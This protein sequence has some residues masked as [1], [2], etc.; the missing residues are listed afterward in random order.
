MHKASYEIWGC[1]GWR[2]GGFGGLLLMRAGWVPAKAGNGIQ[3]PLVH[4]HAMGSGLLQPPGM[5]GPL[6]TPSPEKGAS[7]I[8][9]PG[10]LQGGHH[11]PLPPC[12]GTD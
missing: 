1:S 10:F 9:Y 7:S 3:V 8:P 4:R 5:E 12:L 6:D 2:R 11:G